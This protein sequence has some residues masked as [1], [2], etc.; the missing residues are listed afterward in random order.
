MYSATSGATNLFNFSLSFSF[1]VRLISVAEMSSITASLTNTLPGPASLAPSLFA[2]P[3][4]STRLIAVS[5]LAGA[6][7]IS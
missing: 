2:A 3:R 5:A 4:K 6:A 7:E 1:T